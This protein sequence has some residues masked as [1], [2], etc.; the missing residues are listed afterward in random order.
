MMNLA[1]AVFDQ[2]SSCLAIGTPRADAPPTIA[3]TPEREHRRGPRVA[4][5]GRVMVIP[6]DDAL[7][8]M[9]FQVTVRDLAPGGLGFLHR[10]K[11]DLDTQFVVLLPAAE[12]GPLAVLC[13]VAYWQPLAADRFA[14]GAKFVRVLREGCGIESPPR[15]GATVAPEQVFT[16]GHDLRDRRAA[17]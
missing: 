15:D 7:G 9:P 12:S 14:I 13:T 8:L 11:I 2:V 10:R 17:S 3:A 6:F 16:P 4:G 5:R 1:P